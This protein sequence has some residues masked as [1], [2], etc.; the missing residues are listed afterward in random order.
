V[1]RQGAP[2]R[3]TTDATR[4]RQVLLNLLGNAVKFTQQGSVELRLQAEAGGTGLRIEVAD[5]GPGIPPELRAQLF[6]DFSRQDSRETAAIEGSG[7]GL[8]LAARLAKLLG[9]RIGQSDNIGGGSLFWL[10]LPLIIAGLSVPPVSAL[11]PA[12][13][14]L[15]ATLVPEPARRLRV[16]VADDAD[17]N[18]DIIRGFLSRSHEVTCVAGGAEAVE[19]AANADYDVILMDV[20]M[21]EVDGLEATRRIRRLAGARG[22]IPIIGVTAQAFAEQVAACRMAGMDAHLPKPFSPEMLLQ[23]VVSAATLRNE[24]AADVAPPRP[25]GSLIRQ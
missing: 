17:M 23:A 15:L 21:P 1:A 19:A 7:L 3:L 20:R 8:A 22:S 24:R 10:E 12:L 5:T 2:R 16:L 14:P 9:G 25:L 6:Q 4:L 18:R 13:S 11:A